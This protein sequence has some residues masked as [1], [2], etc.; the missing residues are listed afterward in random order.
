MKDISLFAETLSLLRRAKDWHIS[1][2][3]RMLEH[4]YSEFNND[5]WTIVG[6]TKAFIDEMKENDFDHSRVKYCRS[7]LF[8][9][10]DTAENVLNSDMS[11]EEVLN[12]MESRD[13]TVLSLRSENKDDG[14]LKIEYEHEPSPDLFISQYI[15][16]SMRKKHE[17]VYLRERFGPK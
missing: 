10:R 14:S 6:F 16:F 1:T 13:K 7:H 9:R 5:D 8:K 17:I 11:A 4:A 3:Q 12:Y 15:G 2:R